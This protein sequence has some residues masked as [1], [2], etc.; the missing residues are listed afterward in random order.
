MSA[1]NGKK[2]DRFSIA[3]VIPKYGLVGGGERFAS[4]MTGRLARANCFDIHVFANKWVDDTAGLVTFHKVPI[5][6]FPKFLRP[7]SFAM[8]A[9]RMIGRGKFDL[10]HSHDRFVG[11]DIYS[12]HCVPHAGW[13]RDVRRKRP[14]HFDR[15]VIAVEKRMIA[16]GAFSCFLPV[17]TLAIE[18]F[19]SEYK[20]LPGTWRPVHPGVD[21]AKFSTP[22]VASCRSEVRARHGIGEKDFLV[23]F[24]GMNFEVKGLDTVIKAVALARNA[25]PGAS[26]RLLVVGRGDERK[27][28][29]MAEGLGAGEAVRFAGTRNEGLERYYRAADCFAM[30][31]TFDT[32]GMVVLEAMASGLPV[33]ISKGVGAKDLVEEGVNGFVLGD[34]ADANAAAERIARLIDGPRRA[35]MGRRALHTASLHDWDVLAESMRMLYMKVLSEKG[36]ALAGAKRRLDTDGPFGNNSIV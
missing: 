15:A 32:F 31:S 22:S 2:P 27:Y 35:E 17:S 25:F 4:E 29:E 7:L 14:S 8:C 26:I 12:V 28:R 24:V 34:C 6:S 23:L 30:L 9:R 11:A 19:Q 10:V 33:I 20:S 36:G 16:T 18:A 5:V 3:V 13:V 21:V 1:P